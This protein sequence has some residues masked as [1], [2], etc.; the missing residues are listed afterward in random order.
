MFSTGAASIGRHYAWWVEVFARCLS[1]RVTYISA[2]V[3]SRAVR[4]G[5]GGGGHHIAAERLVKN[6]DPLRAETVCAGAHSIYCRGAS[7]VSAALEL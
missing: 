6:I 1:I 2:G 3:C 5:G 7:R 4:G